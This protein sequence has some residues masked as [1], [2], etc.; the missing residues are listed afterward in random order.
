METGRFTLIL[1]GARSGKSDYAEKLAAEQA[2]KV[3][4]GAHE[5]TPHEPGSQPR[6]GQVLY[7]ATAQA[8]DAEMRTRI[9]RHR[10]GRPAHWQT[11]EAARGVGQAVQVALEGVNPQRAPQVVLLDCMTLLTSNVLMELPEDISE[12][13][14]MA[15]L[16]AELEPLL[17]A[18]RASS[19]TWVVVSNEVGLGIVPAYA[20]GRVYR[21]VLGRVNRQLAEVADRVLFMVAGLP[22]ALKSPESTLQQSNLPEDSSTGTER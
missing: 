2:A 13:D 4:I 1:G 3:A 15:A 21:D 19:A 20:L 17:A 12:T 6:D 11:L 18:Y 22:L 14:A 9:E 16:Q 8:W 10:A 5:T 7:V